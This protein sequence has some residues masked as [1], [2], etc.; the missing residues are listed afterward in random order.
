ML[1]TGARFARCSCTFLHLF[2]TFSALGQ[3]LI[4]GAR[5][6]GVFLG[7]CSSVWGG[8]GG[9][10]RA[11]VCTWCIGCACAYARATGAHDARGGRVECVSGCVLLSLAR[12]GW[13][14]MAVLTYD[15]AGGLD[16]SPLARLEPPPLCGGGFM[17]PL[18]AAPPTRRGGSPPRLSG[19]R[20]GGAS[21]RGRQPASTPARLAA[22]KY[23]QRCP[24]PEQ[25]ARGRAATPPQVRG[26][27]GGRGE[28]WQQTERRRRWRGGLP[29]RAT[30]SARGWRA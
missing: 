13:A 11:R 28:L 23:T 7:G 21:P 16:G 8:S 18:L 29:Q 1:L 25:G 3:E 15:K 20:Y 19:G 27:S 30:R 9:L 22:P 5:G 4:A 10:P 17:L 26:R 2:C 24:T 12:C 6:G 14:I